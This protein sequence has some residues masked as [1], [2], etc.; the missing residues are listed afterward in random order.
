[1]KYFMFIIAL[2]LV[3]FTSCNTQLP[4]DSGQSAISE[5]SSETTNEP[6]TESAPQPII[7]VPLLFTLPYEFSATDLFGNSVTHE[8][9]GEKQVFLVHLW[10]TWC[11]PCVRGMPNLAELA[12]TYGDKVGFIGLIGD[13][14]TNAARAIEI[15]ESAGVPSSFIMLDAN[16][17]NISH[18]REI[19]TSG[20]FPTT[21]ILTKG[22]PY[23][24]FVGGQD[25]ALILAD[26]LS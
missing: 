1:M 7:N 16:D 15:T 14:D 8:T 23:E 17:P 18:L 3:M 5:P 13:F 22:N 11:A 10:V 24:Q 25:Y 21:A 6:V 26:A 19:V 12:G 2:C 20:F 4:D 9:L